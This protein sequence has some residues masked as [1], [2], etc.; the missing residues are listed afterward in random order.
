MASFFHSFS[1]NP[2]Q[3]IV[4]NIF[5]NKYRW[6]AWDSKPGPQR[7]RMVG[8]P[9]QLV[10][11]ETSVQD[12]VGSNPSTGY[13]IDIF[14]LNCCKKLI[15]VRKRPKIHERGRY[16]PIFLKR[17]G[18]A[19]M[20]HWAIVTPRPL[21]WNF[22][23]LVPDANRAHLLFVTKSVRKCFPRTKRRVLTALDK[24]RLFWQKYKKRQRDLITFQD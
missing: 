8:S 10:W 18:W 13:W 15:F 16:W 20:I 17:N 9:G 5:S 14:T 22:A 3:L 24:F 11:E 1:T 2:W 7:K 6:C 19:Q 12:V 4:T 21:S 23:V